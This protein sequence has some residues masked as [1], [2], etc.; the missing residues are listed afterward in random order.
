M[1][2]V[3]NMMQMLADVPPMLAAAWVMWFVAGGMLAM[4]Y[5]RASLELEYA[6]VA[7][8]RAVVARPKTSR[9]P[10]GVRREAAPVEPA[11]EV[12]VADTSHLYEPPPALAPIPSREK[13]PVVIGD[14]FGDL[15]TLL[16]QPPQAAPVPQPHRAPGD[17]PILSSSGA[18]FRR[19]NDH[20]PKLS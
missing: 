4:W 19:A 16:D 11:A 3:T 14:P 13:K 17:S 7:A 9:P 8:P 20:E 5:R 1:G 6:P 12:P 18:P 10:S 2:M 15:A